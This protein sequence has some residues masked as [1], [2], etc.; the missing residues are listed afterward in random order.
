MKELLTINQV[1]DYLQVSRQTVYEYFSDKENPLPVFYLSDRTPRV[2]KAEL[3]AWMER[4]ATIQS[5]IQSQQTDSIA[6]GD[7]GNGK[8]GDL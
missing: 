6:A 1:A 8:G 5:N 3:E 7:G 2:K 4:Q